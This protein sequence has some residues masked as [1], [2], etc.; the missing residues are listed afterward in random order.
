MGLSKEEMEEF[1]EIMNDLAA[2]EHRRIR[3]DSEHNNKILNQLRLDLGTEYVEDIIECLKESEAHG[4]LEIIDDPGIKPQK[5]D[6]GSF[7]HILVDQYLNGGMEGDSFA[8]YVYI[9][10]MGKK[11]LKSHYSM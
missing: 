10:L 1:A 5:E 4:K 8:G 11:Y 7:D 2:E 3:E 9:P 6:W